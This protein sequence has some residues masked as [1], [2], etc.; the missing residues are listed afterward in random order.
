MRWMIENGLR[1]VAGVA[2]A[3]ALLPGPAAGQAVVA[4]AD[5]YRA[6]AQRLERFL[7]HEVKD[8]ELPAL[9]IALVDDQQIVWARGFGLAN[10]RGKVSAT[11]ETVYRVGSVSKLFTDVAVMQ[12]VER[13]TLDLDAP[14]TSYLPDF[15]PANS[16]K[17]A[18][19]LRQLMAHRSGLVREPPV[20]HYFDPTAPS[21][22]DTVRSLNRTELLY[23]PGSRTKYSNAAIAVV[24]YVLQHT[25]NEAFARYLQRH[26]LDPL[27]LKKSGFEETP[28]LRR[29]LAAALMW[30]YHG[31]TFPAPTFALGMAPAGSMYSTVNDLGRF[32]SALFAGGRG[33]NGRVLKP[34]TLAAMWQPQFAKP[35]EKTGFG[36]GF[37]IQELAGRRLVGH[38]GAIY[39][40][41]TE[42][43]ALPDEKLGVVVIASRDCANAV[44]RHVAAVALEQLLAVRR[45]KPLPAIEPST[46]LPS[47]RA[48]ELAGRY[49]KGEKAF[50]LVE[51]TGRLYQWPVRGGF[52]AEVRAL[53]QDLIADDA[54]VHGKRLKVEKGRLVQGK[55]TYP[56][57]ATP[58]GVAGPRPEPMP[59]RWAGLIGEY[60]WDHNT[61]YILEKDGRLHALIEWFFLYPLKEEVSGTIFKFPDWGLYDGEKIVFRRDEAGRATLALAAGVPFRRRPLDGE[62]GQTFKIKPLRPLDV[63]RREALAA[64]PPRETGDFRKPDLVE[65]VK[66][67]PTIKLD[68]RYA[69]TD[70]FLSTPFYRSARA[71]L[72]RPAAEALVRVHRSLRALGFG[73]LIHDGYRPWFV[74]KMFWEATPPKDRIFVADP[75]QG[76]RH[77]RGCAVDLT[78][79]E[80]KTGKAVA[81]V[82]GFDE[83]SDRSFP[84]YLG[85]TSRQRWN[86]DLLR[87]A[88]EAEGFTVYEAEWWHFDY[89]DWRKYPI[90]NLTF[91]K[92]GA[93]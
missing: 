34:Q 10:P 15:K 60:G 79:Y 64:Q 83:M 17:K 27:G 59:G 61:L 50:D 7:A 37:H 53:G 56:R 28:A 35:K 18:I 90:L 2:L 19:T 68:I 52:R 29:D 74:T 77:N 23:A 91:E 5:K 49:G 51:R 78:L 62:N 67:D 92:I 66:L 1:P 25:R 57:A 30:T 13:G 76:S 9:S 6:V 54:L 43:A 24:G 88:M 32:L 75:A 31:R 20:G 55:E 89:K 73:L 14:V 33:V 11:A 8:K 39:G 86:R 85:G 63:L 45:G 40:F 12:L 38:G 81:M 47:R 82:G 70:N 46:P 44:T 69:S 87:R 80:R 72:Q 4:P 93:K 26:V 36:I 3:L 42:L 22:A 71:F 84:D 21:L 48:L 58:F 16:F 41:A 65:L